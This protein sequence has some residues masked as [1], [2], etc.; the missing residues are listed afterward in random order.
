MNR[1]NLFS[2]MFVLLLSGCGDSYQPAKRD[3]PVAP[4]TAAPDAVAEQ[5]RPATEEG[6]DGEL[7]L[8]AFRMTAPESWVRKQPRSQFV[9]FEF[10]LPVADGQGEGGRL[11]ISTAG[12]SIE[13]N[14]DR[15]RGQ[16]GGSPE[17]D[18]QEEREIAGQKVTVVDFSGTFNDQAGPFAPGVQ[19]EGYRMLGAIVPAGEMSHFIKAYGPEETMAAHEAAFDEFLQSLRQD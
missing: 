2:V 10:S 6:L 3:M 1:R 17:K 4:E 13:A 18:S 5:D 19:H 12:G 14:L 7:T 16:F 11:T 15:W 8:G 9:Q